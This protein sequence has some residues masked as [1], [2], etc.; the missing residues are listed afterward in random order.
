MNDI[1]KNIVNVEITDWENNQSEKII[2]FIND[3]KKNIP[4]R[5]FINDVVSNNSAD[6]G[7]IKEEYNF[8]PMAE[9]ISNNIEEALEEFGDSVSK[10]EKINILK[11][12][13]D[14]ML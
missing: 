10:E 14:R 2:Q 4:D 11:S 6:I 12:L 3:L 5:K 13:I 7:S 1:S 8:S 9:M